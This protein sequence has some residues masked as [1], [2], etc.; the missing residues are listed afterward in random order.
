MH[1]LFDG[2]RVLKIHHIPLGQQEPIVRV[3]VCF[4]PSSVICN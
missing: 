4:I 1:I 2:E 3:D